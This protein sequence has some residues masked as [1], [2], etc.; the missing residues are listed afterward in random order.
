MGNLQVYIYIPLCVYVCVCMH[1]CVCV[2][3]SLSR[4]DHTVGLPGSE[5]VQPHDRLVAVV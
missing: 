5:H 1:V 4:A 3:V 2:C